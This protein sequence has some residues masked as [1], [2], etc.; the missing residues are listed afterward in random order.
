MLGYSAEEFCGMP[1]TQITHPDDVQL[2][3]H[4]FTELVSGKR[5]QY[6]LKSGTT[7]KTAVWSGGT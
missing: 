5:D 7:A 6:Q 2:D 3:R 4:L 1:F